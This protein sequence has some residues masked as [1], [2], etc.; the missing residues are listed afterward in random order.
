MI[1]QDI[2]GQPRAVT[3]LENAIR[4]DSLAGSYLFAGPDGVGKYSTAIAFAKAL[5]GVNSDSEPAA[6]AIDAGTFPDVRTVEP[7]GPSHIIRIGQL[8]PRDTEP[9][10]ALLRDIYFEPMAGPRRVFIIKDAEGLN[11]SSGNSLLKTL[12]EPPSYAQFILTASSTAGILP[13]I[14]SRCQRVPF[15][16]LPPA[17][18]EEALM[19][20]FAVPAEQ[21]RFLAAYCEG[22]LGL[23]VMLARSP[24]LLAA[25]DELLD[26]AETLTKAPAIYSFKAGE[27]FRKLAPKLKMA[28]DLNV[29]SSEDKGTRESL[30]RALDLLALYY[31][32]LLSCRV[33][34]PRPFLVNV[35]RQVQIAAASARF[36]P[37]E[38]EIALSSI[39][40]VRHAIERN[41]NAQLSI[42]VLFSRLT[43]L[44]DLKPA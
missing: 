35:D 8:W 23:A 14:V 33:G 7:Q 28:A 10:N 30:A 36:Q 44:S 41:A 16:T 42:D 25:R 6:R 11:E 20:K 17:A 27:E 32:D 13:T 22:R 2:L 34:G 19:K 26:L 18:I 21:A 1:L 5:C 29:D 40:A 3:I 39:S 9:D 43:S 15:G 31:R 38:L 4:N 37:A 24:K 12:E